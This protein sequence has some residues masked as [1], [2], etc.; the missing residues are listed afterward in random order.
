MATGSP[1]G[2]ASPVNAAGYGQPGFVGADT[3][4]GNYFQN[5]NGQFVPYGPNGQSPGG[6][7]N[8]SPPA[9]GSPGGSPGAAALV[10]GQ[11]GLVSSVGVSVGD[12]SI[13]TV[14]GISAAIVGAY[15][16]GLIALPAAIGFLVVLAGIDIATRGFTDMLANL[17]NWFRGTDPNGRPIP[18]SPFRPGGP[19]SKFA[20]GYLGDFVVAVT[21][22]GAIYWI[23]H[24]AGSPQIEI[25]KSDRTRA[26]PSRIRRRRR[27][28]AIA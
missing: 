14:I 13:V 7:P 12:A 9:A 17:E 3:P 24:R 10:S 16:A 6:S 18:S 21:I 23:S 2:A 20:S 28:R 26:N 19:L 8:G 27:R 22:S 11:S 1:D 4:N 5:S 15:Y 25:I